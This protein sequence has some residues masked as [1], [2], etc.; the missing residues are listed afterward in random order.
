M[1]D[2]I[3]IRRRKNERNRAYQR[4]CYRRITVS[5]ELFMPVLPLDWN[6]SL[7]LIVYTLQGDREFSELW[8]ELPNINN[9]V[10]GAR[11]QDSLRL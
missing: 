3:S 9:L 4:I 6:W 2:K 7:G 8:K 11:H 5:F 10:V 1:K